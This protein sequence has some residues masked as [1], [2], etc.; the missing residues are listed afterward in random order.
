MMFTHF[1]HHGLCL[2]NSYYNPIPDLHTFNLYILMELNVHTIV[3]LFYRV[4]LPSSPHP[5]H[6]YETTSHPDIFQLFS[7]SVVV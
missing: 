1:L 7:Y 3:F 4:T 2:L 6:A 5:E